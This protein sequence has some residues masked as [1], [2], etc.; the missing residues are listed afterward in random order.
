MRRQAD[1]GIAL[2]I[3]ISILAIVSIMA[4]SFTF[5]MRL[6]AK[7]AINYQISTQAKYLAE[8]GLAHAREVLRKDGDISRTD[9]DGEFWR[10]LFKG[11]DVDNN[12]DGTPDSAWINFTDASGEVIG[13]YAVLII[14]ELGKINLN[15]A[16][17]FP[18]DPFVEQDGITP[19]E[20][21]HFQYPVH[22]FLQLCI[23][24]TIYAAKESDVLLDRQIVIQGKL[25]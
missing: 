18:D 23:T 25:L 3:V 21:S 2:I 22:P 8:A 24:E 9:H 20:V 4:I 16:G 14:D 10:S 19:F 5:T 13:R 11:T 12:S 1:K 7:T 6:E 17:W 15:S